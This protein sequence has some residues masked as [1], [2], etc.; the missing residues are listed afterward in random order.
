MATPNLGELTALTND[1]ARESLTDNIFNAN[2]LLMK[3]REN[4]ETFDGGE[5]IR[6][7]LIYDDDPGDTTG[8]SISMTATL[9]HVERE[10][11]D[12]AQFSWAEYYQEVVIWA[13]Q[14]HACSG[15]SQIVS[16]VDARL[17]TAQLRMRKRFSRHIYGSS[18]GTTNILGLQDLFS[19]TNTYGNISRASNSWWQPYIDDNSGTGRALTLT[20]MENVY[21]AISDGDVKPDLIVTSDAVLA[22]Y[23]SL[24]HPNQ[25]FQDDE[26]ARAGFRNVLFNGTPVVS[27]KHCDTDASDRHKMYFLN[28]QFLKWRPHKDENFE[29]QEGG[30]RWMEHGKGIFTRIYWSGNFTCNNCRYQGRLADIDPTL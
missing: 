8:G 23:K 15:K 30:W 26:L 25:R 28:F 27:D 24:L 11:V 18:A 9:N 10:G 14:L 4:E 2:V 1:W 12:A 5:Y 17:Q 6:E 16:I 22:K 7:P 13:K 29:Q 21:L 19:E 20:L 3:L